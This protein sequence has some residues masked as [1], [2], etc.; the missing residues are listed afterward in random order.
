VY[1]ENISTPQRTELVSAMQMV[2]PTH[3]IGAKE[4]ALKEI[5]A[6]ES[7][8]VDKAILALD[9]LIAFFASTTRL[10]LSYYLGEKQTGGLGDTGESTDEIKIMLKKEFILRHFL[11]ELEQLYTVILEKPFPAGLGEF[12]AKKRDELNQRMDA[13]NAEDEMDE[14][15][16]EGT[17][18][19]KK[20]Q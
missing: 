10:P 14:E 3:G 4:S 18:S 1:G 17:D 6:I 9:Q 12:Y 20:A 15:G 2:G 11:K 19:K 7:G 5:R 13:Q 16:T 8:A